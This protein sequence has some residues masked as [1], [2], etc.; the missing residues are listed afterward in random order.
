MLIIPLF[1]SCNYNF[2]FILRQ[3]KLEELTQPPTTTPM[4]PFYVDV[5]MHTSNEGTSSCKKLLTFIYF[6][7][8]NFVRYFIIIIFNFKL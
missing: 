7:Y 1:L 3:Y 4:T 8:Y 6:T 5:P 2:F